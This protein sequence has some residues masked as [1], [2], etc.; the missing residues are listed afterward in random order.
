MGSERRGTANQPGERGAVP[1]PIILELRYRPECASDRITADAEPEGDTRADLARQLNASIYNAAQS[2]A[3]YE[4]NGA[5]LTFFCA[6]GCMAE[7]KRSLRDYVTQG[8][9]IAGHARS[10]KG[11]PR[12][13]AE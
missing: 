1:D 11:I 8:A 9:V 5:E 6:C 12:S 2:S 7:V 10:P 13:A 4:E 3:H